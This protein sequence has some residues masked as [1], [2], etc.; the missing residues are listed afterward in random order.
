LLPP[1]FTMLTNMEALRR[2]HEL[3]RLG[4]PEVNVAIIFGWSVSDVRRAL[5]ER[6]RGTAP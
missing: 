6:Q 3:V 1:D 2:V 4:L 5:G